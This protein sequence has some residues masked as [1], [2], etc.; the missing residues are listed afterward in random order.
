MQIYWEQKKAFTQGKSLSTVFIRISAQPRIGVHLESAPILKAE[1]D[2]KRPPHRTSLPIALKL[3][4]AP[5]PKPSTSPA[6]PP[7]PL[8]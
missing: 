2:N 8:N 5:N 7:P 3:N 1:K 4:K 6:T